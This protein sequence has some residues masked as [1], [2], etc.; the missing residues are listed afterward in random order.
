[1]LK[2]QEREFSGQFRLRLPKS[3]HFGLAR[4]AEEQGVSLNS[5]ILYLLSTRFTQEKA[6][7]A[8]HRLQDTVQ[9]VHEMVS[10]ITVGETEPA[11]FAWNSSGS[12]N[13]VTQ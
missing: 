7:Q 1:M 11:G 8:E 6:A 4:E 3:L 10:S 13:Y 2:N 5:Y 9:E 12:S